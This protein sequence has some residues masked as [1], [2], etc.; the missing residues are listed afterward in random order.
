MCAPLK[1]GRSGVLGVVQLINKIGS[2]GDSPPGG[3]TAD[4]RQFLQVFASQAA[5]AIA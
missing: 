1:A 3:F 2:G 4:D 5:A